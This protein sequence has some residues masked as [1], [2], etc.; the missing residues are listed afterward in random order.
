MILLFKIAPKQ[1]AEVLSGVSQCEKA[2]ICPMEKVCVLDELVSWI[3]VLLATSSM[4][5]DQPYILTKMSL[6]RNTRKTR[7][8]IDRWM[9]MLEPE[10]LRDLTLY[11]PWE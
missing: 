2:V 10:A 3:S 8:C 6:N 1:S 5:T 9:K 4:R 11:S 7:L